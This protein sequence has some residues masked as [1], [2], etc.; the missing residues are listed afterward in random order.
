[1]AVLSVAYDSGIFGT[2]RTEFQVLR[3]LLVIL[4]A[5]RDSGQWR[6]GDP[7]PELLTE[8]E[9]IRYLRLDSIDIKNPGESLKRYRDLEAS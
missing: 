5:M 8:D 1:M 6:P 7:C 2:P 9:A 4:S 3:D